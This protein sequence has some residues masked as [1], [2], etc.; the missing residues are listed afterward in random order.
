MFTALS[1]GD[2][3]R[4]RKSVKH[5]V[6]VFFVPIL[7]VATLTGAASAQGVPTS[8]EPGQ[9]EKNLS[10]PMKQNVPSLVPKLRAAP[11]P[12]A[13]APDGAKDMTFVLKELAVEGSSV[14]SKGELLEAVKGKVGQEISVAELFDIASTLTARYRNDG[15]LLSTVVVP[16]QKIGS[17]KV[18]LKAVEGYLDRIVVEGVTSNQKTTILSYLNKVIEQRPLKSKNLER[19]LLLVDDLSGLSLK[20]FMKPS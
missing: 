4:L 3:V 12:A 11:K 16:P 20:T 2:L 10:S 5:R 1:S 15:Y 13:V 17:G 19:Y 18:V 6:T 9:I 7:V 14:Y 8:V